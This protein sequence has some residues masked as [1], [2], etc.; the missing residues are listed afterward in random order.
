MNAVVFTELSINP[1]LLLIKLAMKSLLEWFSAFAAY[2]ALTGAT[3][4]LLNLAVLS[5]TSDHESEYALEIGTEFEKSYRA[6]IAQNGSDLHYLDKLRSLKKEN[7]DAYRSITFT[8]QTAAFE[9]CQSDPKRQ[10][11]SQTISGYQQ[12]LDANQP[13]MREPISLDAAT[14]KC[15][16]IFFTNNL[17]KINSM[18]DLN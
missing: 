4:G 15:I 3:F 11:T 7:Y 2:R 13:S 8:W 10:V 12:L 1:L 18:I 9:S 6:V 5:C 14:R 17:Q 16:E